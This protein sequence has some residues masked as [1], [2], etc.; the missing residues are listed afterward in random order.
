MIGLKGPRCLH[1]HGDITGS[2]LHQ[3]VGPTTWG[4]YLVASGADYDPSADRTTVQFRY[5]TTYDLSSTQPTGD[6]TT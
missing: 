4:E 1:Y 5:A 3:V 2:A 6:P